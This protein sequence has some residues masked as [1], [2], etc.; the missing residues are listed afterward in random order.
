MKHQKTAVRKRPIT[1][2][3]GSSTYNAHVLR[4]RDPKRCV[5][6]RK[7]DPPRFETTLRAYL[8]LCRACCRSYDR[9]RDKDVSML[10]LI[11]WAADRAWVSAQKKLKRQP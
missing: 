10:S 7:P 8:G 9:A 5:V 3:P 2:V 1:R 4:K 11:T 6:C